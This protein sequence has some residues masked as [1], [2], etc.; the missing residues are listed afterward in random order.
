MSADQ[1]P[2][3]AIPYSEIPRRNRIDQMSQAERMIYDAVG[4]VEMMGAHPRLS[5]AVVKL[6]EARAA[7]ADFVDEQLEQPESPEESLR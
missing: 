5:D 1:K 3:S 4:A 6:G 7:V 2:E